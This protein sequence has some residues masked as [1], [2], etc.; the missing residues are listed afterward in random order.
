MIRGCGATVESPG[1]G[2]GLRTAGP[3][4]RLW[5][6]EDGSVIF[7]EIDWPVAKWSRAM[8][9]ETETQTLVLVCRRSFR[10]ILDQMLSHEGLNGIRHGELNLI[11][12]S[13]AH[14]R[15]RE[16][17]EVLLISTDAARTEKLISLLRACPL[18]G[19]REELFELYTV[20]AA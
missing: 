8:R 7:L 10:R 19:E 13:A 2:P 11:G 14:A 16:A 20:D 4:G 9:A 3:S 15:A 18:R 1:A 17:T 6:K 5:L 12:G